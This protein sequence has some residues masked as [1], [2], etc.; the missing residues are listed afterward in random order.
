MPNTLVLIHGYSDKGASF[1][2]W[3]RK[4]ADRYERTEQICIC[5]YVSLT[6]DVTIKDLAEGFDLAL[7]T[8]AGLSKD[9]PFDAIVHSTGMLVIRAWLT[10]YAKRRDRLKHLIGI[11]PATFGSPLAQKGRS[12]IG[13]VF[14]GNKH[15][16][17]DFGA[18]GD[19]ILDGLELAS[20]YTWGLAEKDLLGETAYYD[21]DAATPYVHIFC[22]TDTYGGLRTLVSTPGADGTVRQA[23]AG[24]NVRKIVIDLT[25]QCSV[26]NPQ[27]KPGVKR[28]RIDDWRNADIPVHLIEGLNHGTILTDPTDELVGLVRSALQVET[29]QDYGKWL[30]TADARGRFATAKDGIWQQFVVRAYD[31]RL[32]P[33]TD[34]NLQLF[35]SRDSAESR[36]EEFDKNVDVYSKDASYR[37]FLVDLNKFRGMKSLWLSILAESGSSWVNYE[38]HDHDVNA[39]DGPVTSRQGWDAW[40]DL[41]G[42]MGD[43]DGFLSPFTTTLVELYIDREPT[44]K[45]VQLSGR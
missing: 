39:K 28:W 4:L 1:E 23:G 16:G 31:E 45:L 13:A 6:N 41:S 33:I 9:E 7:S 20:P 25:K 12:W 3:R 14:K 26:L 22:G 21:N 34:Y 2:T 37:S 27:A 11:A 8:R 24:F 44:D 18:A 15:L 40:L 5:D 30:Q 32:D 29:R 38:G 35:T 10:S 42:L 19:Q 43:G 17:P 36:V